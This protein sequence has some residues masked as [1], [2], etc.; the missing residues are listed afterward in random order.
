MTILRNI[1]TKRK[2]ILS[3]RKRQLKIL[4]YIKRK[5]NLDKIKHT[6]YIEDK[7]RR[8]K[9]QVINLISLHEWDQRGMAKHQTL[10]RPLKTESCREP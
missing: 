7:R 8:R 9:Q 4:G 10:L 5:T 2:L 6:G 1:A 3:I